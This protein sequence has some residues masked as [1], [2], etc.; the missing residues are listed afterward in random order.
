[1]RITQSD[2]HAY[3]FGQSR[4]GIIHVLAFRKGYSNNVT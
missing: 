4:S 1:M 3:I 2:L